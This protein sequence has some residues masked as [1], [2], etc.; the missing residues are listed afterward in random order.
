VLA[1]SGTG[2]AAGTVLL[3]A[4]DESQKILGP[5]G[6]RVSALD[7]ERSIIPDLMPMSVPADCRTAPACRDSS[8]LRWGSDW[9]AGHCISKGVPSDLEV[10]R[11]VPG[12][13]PAALVAVMRAL[14]V[15]CDQMT[16]VTSA[17]SAAS[18]S[19]PRC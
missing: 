1:L 15:R 12:A 19:S 2:S 7:E 13:E 5:S 11:T 9:S 3:M 16:S 10:V 18:L 17:H 6:E 8:R 14:V 4:S